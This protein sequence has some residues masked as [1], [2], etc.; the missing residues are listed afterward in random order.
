MGVPAFS[1]V[2]QC[3]LTFTEI[4]VYWGIQLECWKVLGLSRK[5]IKYKWMVGIFVKY[6]NIAV[7]QQLLFAAEEKSRVA[8]N[9]VYRISEQVRHKPCCTPIEDG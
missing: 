9:P 5:S 6:S 8:R 3:N 4:L 2:S 7:V 1:T